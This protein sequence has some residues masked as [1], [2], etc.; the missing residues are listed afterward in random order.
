VENLN[1]FVLTVSDIE[2]WL[3]ENRQAW[4]QL[5]AEPFLWLNS[6][7]YHLY[8]TLEH[9]MEYY[10]LLPDCNAALARLR[11]L[12]FTN[13]PALH[14]WLQQCHATPLADVFMFEVDYFDWIEEVPDGIIKIREGIYTEL[15]PL[16]N[17]VCF[18]KVYS[19]LEWEYVLPE[20]D[21]NP[22]DYYYNE[23]QITRADWDF[24]HNP[25]QP[26]PAVLQEMAQKLE[27]IFENWYDATN[28]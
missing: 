13:Y 2:E 15:Q 1:R 19:L 7:F 28:N 18:S 22:N 5:K 12:S 6:E 17:L 3:A 11:G 27:A 20:T 14:Q 23:N 10:R 24:T 8:C 21:P 26:K 4:L 25:P 9:F 16:K